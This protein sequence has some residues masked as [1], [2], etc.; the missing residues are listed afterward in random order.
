MIFCLGEG[1]FKEQ[2]T[3]YQKNYHAF[4]KKVTEERYVEILELIKSDILKD[5]KLKLQDRSWVDEWKKVTKE[6]W[7]RILEI[8]EAD[9]EVIEGIISFELEL[10]DKVKITVEGKDKYISRDSAKELNL[11]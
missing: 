8:P 5:L 9:K 6:Q 10:D 3:G 11:I 2:G 1:R 7:K 4:N